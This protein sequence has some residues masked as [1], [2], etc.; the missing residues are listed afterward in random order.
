M[1]DLYIA[2][3][4]ICQFSYFELLCLFSGV[5]QDPQP[6]RQVWRGLQDRSVHVGGTRRGGQSRLQE[7]E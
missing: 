6:Q 4:L 7:E 1:S 5:R 2:N 3:F